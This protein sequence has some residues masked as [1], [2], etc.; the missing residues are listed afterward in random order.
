MDFSVLIGGAAGQGLETSAHIL[1]HILKRCGYNVFTYRDY[2]SR[3]RGGHNFTQIRFSDRELN[4][5]TNKVDIVLALNEETV[6]L[7]KERLKE[8]G[9]IICDED[10]SNGDRTLSLPFRKIIGKI[11]NPKV[12]NTIGLGVI[13]KYFGIP[14]DIGE[15]VL[16]SYLKARLMRIINL[17]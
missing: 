2:M 10:I 6:L 16:E 15:G 17:L 3:V 12:I 8:E 13:L 4:S 11:K 1:E 9:I 14:L 7:H 5:F